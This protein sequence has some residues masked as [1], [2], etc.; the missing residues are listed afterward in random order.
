M[1]FSF[2]INLRINFC[3]TDVNMIGNWQKMNKKHS[4]STVA[5]LV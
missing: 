3:S 1:E 4:F 5:D 2:A